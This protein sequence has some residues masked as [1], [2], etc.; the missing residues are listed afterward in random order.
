MPKAELVFISVPPAGLRNLLCA[1]GSIFSRR[2][3][4][5]CTQQGSH[6]SYMQVIN[7]LLLHSMTI[8]YEYNKF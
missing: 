2:E 3:L 1:Y 5:C 4:S 6:I 7:L 8:H